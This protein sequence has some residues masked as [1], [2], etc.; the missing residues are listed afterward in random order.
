MASSGPFTPL[1]AKGKDG[2]E[3]DISSWVQVY[4]CYISEDK[5]RSEGRKISKEDCA[6]CTRVHI[7][8]ILGSCQELSLQACPEPNKKHPRDWGNFG[9]VRVQ[10]KTPDGA[11]AKP[12][13]TTR[14]QLYRAIAKVLPDNANRRARLE[15]MAAQ[16]AAAKA[17]AAGGGK[18]AAAAAT[19]GTSTKPKKKKGRKKN[20]R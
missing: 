16:Q 20:R 12:E 8:D 11:F 4:P 14:M 17:A 19:A 13:I 10:L 7:G 9:R 2:E 1:V 5:R 18:G 3:I 15:H 6:G